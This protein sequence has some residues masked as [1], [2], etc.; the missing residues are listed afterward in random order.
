MLSSPTSLINRSVA[1]LLPHVP[2]PLVWRI[3][4]RYIAGVSLEDAYRVIRKLNA[5]GAMATLDVLGE[6]VTDPAQVTGYR[7]LYLEALEAIADQGLDCNISVK[8][9]ELG[10]RFDPERCLE[11]MAQLA[12][13]AA[14]RGKPCS[15]KFTLPRHSRRALSVQRAG[16]RRKLR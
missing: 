16:Q 5:L 14:K 3:S 12:D 6:D 8:L 10:L 1:A 9:S 15:R 4:R 13:A 7:D 11:I 2:R